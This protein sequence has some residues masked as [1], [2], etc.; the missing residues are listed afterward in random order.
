MDE[1]FTTKKASHNYN[2]RKRDLPSLPYIMKQ[3]WTDSLFIHYPV[4]QQVLQKYVPDVLP[5]DTYDGMGWISVVPYLTSSMK[6]RGFP[7]IPGA[8]QFPG[9]NVRTYVIVNGRP[10]IYFFSLTAA[11]L[12]A[13]TAA[14]FF[15]RL[16]YY[17]LEIYM[18]NHN[19]LVNFH[20]K[21][22]KKSGAQLICNYK[23]ISKPNPAAKG[24]LDEWLVERYCLFT[25]TKKGVPLRCNILHR[26]W[27]LQ[28]VEVEI[29]KNTILSAL[30]ISPATNEV[31]MHF[32]KRADVSIWP[33]VP[34]IYS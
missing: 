22:I 8:R 17:Y 12:I 14:R 29:H 27:L 1:R 18:D 3:T 10:G 23:P 19:E 5:I 21:S 4:N 7:S 15:F 33:L 32:S 34:A 9:Y 31:I 6:L 24:S 30:N 11:N 16:P 20:S 28:D 13:S 25:I 26:S 2:T